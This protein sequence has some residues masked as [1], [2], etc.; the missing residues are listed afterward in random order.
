M[1][2]GAFYAF[3]NIQ[4]TGLSSEEFCTQ[5]L[6]AQKV[7]VVPGTAFGGCGEGFI[8]A[9]YATAFEKLEQAVERMARFLGK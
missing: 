2:E 1:P 3:A 9:S 7:A 5:L 8:R 6:R 4:S